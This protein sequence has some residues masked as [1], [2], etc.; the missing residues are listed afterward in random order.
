MRRTLVWDWKKGI[1]KKEEGDGKGEGR[2]LRKRGAEEDKSG[3]A[4]TEHKPPDRR[5]RIP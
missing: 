4:P 1:M 5:G 3:S 2:A